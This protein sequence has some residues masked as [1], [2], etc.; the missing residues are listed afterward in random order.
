MHS[1]PEKSLMDAQKTERKSVA[2]TDLGAFQSTHSGL[3]FQTLSRATWAAFVLIGLTIGLTHFL[4]LYQLDENGISLATNKSPTWD[5]TNLWFGGRLALDGQLSTIFEVEAYRQGLR[6]IFAPY[7]ADSEWSY[8]PSILLLGVPLAMVPLS[9]AYAVWTFGTL[10][11]L[12]VVARRVGFSRLSCVLLWLS[13]GVWNNALFGQ[14]GALTASLFVGGLFYAH[15]RPRMAGL[16]FAALTV[17]PHLGLLIPVCLIA[18][19]AWRGVIWSAAFAAILVGLTGFAFG[20][21]VW[22]EFLTI[23]Q[24]LMR[25][26]MEAPYGQGYHAN[27]ST[28]F[29]TARW[30]G[31]EVGPAYAAQLICAATSAGVAWRLWRNRAGDPLLRIAATSILALL[32][33]P[34]GYSYDM[35]LLSFA[36]V[37]VLQSGSMRLNV[38]LIPAWLWPALV[39]GF[40]A[41]IGPVSPLVIAYAAAISI[42]AYR[43]SARGNRSFV[44]ETIPRPPIESLA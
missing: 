39:N 20:V 25:A 18:A 38:L 30:L 33:T 5:F 6:D 16:C 9:G 8:P 24:P 31:I 3:D 28:V 12:T 42:W 14:N 35:V 7:I 17:K 43:Q 27:A 44:R 21:S 29:V 19:R 4:R 40:N 2:K 1:H 11:L 13:P 34:Y 10:L 36:C 15:S 32:A 22:F 41:S 26:I 37:A 23:T